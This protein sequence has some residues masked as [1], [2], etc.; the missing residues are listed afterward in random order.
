MREAGYTTANRSYTTMMNKG[1][2]ICALAVL[3]VASAKSFDV[4]IAEPSIV[5]NLRLKPGEY[6]L[7]LQ[8][9]NAIFTDADGNSFK[10]A[11]N[12][13]Q[14]TKKF[15]DTEVMS[16]KDAGQERIEEIRLEGTKMKLEFN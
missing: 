8:G 2:I 14:E 4:S 12:V 1:L 11:V 7:K 16:T 15:S 3:P 5:H 9:T 10:T 6:R 13:E